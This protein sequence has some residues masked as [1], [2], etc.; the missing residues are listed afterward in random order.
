MNLGHSI[1]HV[2]EAITDHQI[3]HGIAVAI[4]VLLEAELSCQRGML[5][6]GDREWLIRL[7][8]PL[9]PHR[10]RDILETVT[11]DGILDVLFRDKKAEGAV[12]KLVVPDRI[13]QIRFVDLAL[14][15]SVEPTLKAA[16][17]EV[18]ADLSDP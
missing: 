8:S 13:G 15:S 11:F 17:R 3:P 18:V 5:P 2:L 14:D 6:V 12:L 7:G 9:I 16:L 10:I 1:G 4:G